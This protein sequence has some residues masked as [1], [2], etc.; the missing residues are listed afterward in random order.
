MTAHAAERIT[1][2]DQIAAHPFVIGLLSRMRK[3][4]QL[5]VA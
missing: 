4:E 1:K 3:R 2:H 5:A